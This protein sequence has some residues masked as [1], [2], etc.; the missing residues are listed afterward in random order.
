LIV[1]GVVIGAMFVLSILAI[2]AITFL[3]RS[4]ED[5]TSLETGGA[6]AEP[7]TPA[8]QEPQ[9]PPAPARP[10]LDGAVLGGAAS[11]FER[12]LG[13][14]AL[15]GSESPEF[16]T[17]TY[18]PCE[19][20]KRPQVSVT[21]LYGA[22]NSVSFGPCKPR[23]LRS[24]SEAEAEAARY[25]PAGTKKVRDTVTGDGESA[26]VFQSDALGGVY[27]ERVPQ[28][29]DCEGNPVPPGTFTL[30]IMENDWFMAPGTC[31]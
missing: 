26:R 22:A 30:V 4:A 24:L 2:I 3:G 6:V 18:L 21:F 15:P 11:G 16:S 8:P 27:D 10:V 1:V 28:F 12:E 7:Q 9:P 5:T 20:R 13:Q 29:R 14:R 25:F 23:V 19:G 31:P 17:Y